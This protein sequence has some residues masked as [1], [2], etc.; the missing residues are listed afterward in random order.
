[1][2]MGREA[3]GSASAKAGVR[4]WIAIPLLWAFFAGAA[5]A[6]PLSTGPFQ[7]A[8][9]DQGGRFENPSGPVRRAGPLVTVPFLL[10][11][12]FARLRDPVGLPERVKPEVDALRRP[13]RN[14]SV[15]WV[16]H[17][18]LLVRIGGVNFLTDPI[19]SDRAGPTRFTSGFRY[20]APGLELADLPRIDFVVISHNHYDHLDLPSLRR[21]AADH[22]EALFLVPLANGELLRDHGIDRVIELDWG[23]R[24]Q[25]GDVTIYCLPAHHWSRRGLR[26]QRRA[27]WAS[28]AVTSPDRRF[29]FAGD[30]GEF[31]GFRAVG[32]ELGPFDLVAL[33][34]GA[35]EPQ[36]M[37]R[38]FHLDPEQAVRAALALSA[39]RIVGIH[40]GTF[41]LSDEP[42]DE[43]PR[44]L[45]G[46]AEA[47]GF[48]E[49][50]VWL[51]RI[52]ET[53]RF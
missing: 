2:G 42:T 3:Q 35:Y 47:A 31:Q 24:H 34:I 22:P 7:G 39:R 44:R 27:L 11:R 49:E 16:G 41:D 10:R 52:G 29:Y 48:P 53:R 21:L 8:P 28:W 25:M 37:M 6:D 36:A 40:Y 43:P 12:V 14:P 45:R 26:D 20:L 38:P 46:A 13:S 9:R 33:P 30:T 1:M 15:T 17:S 23:G 50:D 51:L 18:T 5:T 4:S 19:W 32:E